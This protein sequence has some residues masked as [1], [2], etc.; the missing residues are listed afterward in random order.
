MGLFNLRYVGKV[1]KPQRIEAL[2]DGT[3][4]IVMTILV[5]ELA[6]EGGTGSLAEKLFNMGPEIQL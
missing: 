6:L 2:S 5:L 3:F 4:A 1:Q